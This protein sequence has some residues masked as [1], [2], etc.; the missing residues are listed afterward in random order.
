MGFSTKEKTPL[1]STG[2]KDKQNDFT[3]VYLENAWKEAY[4]HSMTDNLFKA[5]FKTRLV[6]DYLVKVDRASM[7]N[8]LEVRSPFLDYKL[9]EFAASIPN[10]IKLKGGQQKYLLK[11]LAC[12]YVDKDVFSRKKQGFGIPL[13]H[14]LRNEL[15][16]FVSNLLNAETFTNRKL[17][18][19]T[20]VQK[21]L[22]DH[23]AH[24]KNNVHKIWALVSLELWFK[25]F[26]D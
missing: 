5:S 16:T 19:Q 20:Q 24:K 8:S 2:F 11:K 13:E 23:M 9:A 7:M 26:V 22:Q 12:K 4:G 10:T 25:K 14:W 1:Y 21:I 6:N 17:F 18:N 15:K 3:T